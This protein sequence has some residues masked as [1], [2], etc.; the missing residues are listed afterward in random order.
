MVAS[1]T[2][3]DVLSN[4]DD[5]DVEMDTVEGGQLA[6]PNKDGWYKRHPLYLCRDG[7]S[8]STDLIARVFCPKLAQSENFKPH[9]GHYDAVVTRK[10][11]C[12][13]LAARERALKNPSRKLIWKGKELD[14]VA[15]RAAWEADE[16]TSYKKDLA[17]RRRK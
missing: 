3:W 2:L 8:L 10:F 1:N 17:K 6:I 7:I 5:P 15:L 11:V 14:V 16:D 4:P 9:Y 13:I 12:G